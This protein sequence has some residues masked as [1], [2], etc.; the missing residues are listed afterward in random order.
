MYNRSI[1]KIR[2]QIYLDD[3]QRRVLGRVARRTRRTVSELIRGAIDERYPT[4]KEE[5]LE[6]LRAGVFGVWKERSDFGRTDNYLRQLRRGN[7]VDQGRV[8]R[9]QSL[10]SLPSGRR[11][12]ASSP[13]AGRAG[14]SPGS[15][16][17]HGRW[18][19]S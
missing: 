13:P 4:P 5:F 3:G 18:R 11:T 12:G 10:P 8:A 6:A 7:R 2:T 9:G 19:Q 16:D 17:R 14:S 1:V 15:L